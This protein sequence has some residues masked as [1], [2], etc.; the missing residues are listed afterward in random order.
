MVEDIKYEV[1]LNELVGLSKDIKRS[2]ED[3]ARQASYIDTN[4]MDMNEK[5]DKIIFLLEKIANK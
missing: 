2:C 5:L 4:T 1:D 3:A